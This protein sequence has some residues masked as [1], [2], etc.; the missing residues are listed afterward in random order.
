[1]TAKLSMDTEINQY[2]KVGLSTLNTYILNQGNDN[3]PLAHVLQASPFATPYDEEGN[4]VLTLAGS[5]GNVF[6]PLLDEVN[7]AVIDERKTFS[8]F[9]TGYADIK[10]PYGFTYRFNGGVNLKYHHIGKFEDTYTTKR[11]SGVN[12]SNNENQFTADYTLENI[13]N[14]NYSI[15]KHN[16]FFT[17]LYSYQE[18]TFERTWINSYD[19]YD[20]DVQYYNPSKAEEV[21]TDGEF[22]KWTLLS[23]MARL[24]YNYNDKYLLTATIRHDGS[25]RLAK[26]NKW[27]SFPSIALGWNMKK[28]AFMEDI[29]VLSS[30]KIRASWGNVGSTAI[31][32]YQTISR[33]TD[34]KYILGDNGVKGVKPSSV[35][36]YSL[37]WENTETI[38]LGIDFGLLS[39]RITGTLELY[40][41]KTTNVLL[42]VKLP[43]TSG[44]AD[45]Y[46]TNLGATRNRGWEFNVSAVILPGDGKNQL[47]WSTDFN[48]FGNRFRITDLGPG[49]EQDTGNNRFLG[50]DKY[51]IYSYEADGLWQDTPEDRTLAISYSLC[52]ESTYQSQVLGTIKIKNHHIDYEEDG[53]TPKE[54]QQINED[55]RVF[56]GT[57]A[58][59]FEGGITNRFAY[60]NF[61]LSFLWTYKYGGIITSDMHGGYMNTLRGTYNNLNVDYWTPENTGARWPR[62]TSGTV[63]N[64]GLL[65]RYDGSYLKLRNLTLGYT[66][67]AVFLQK[68]SVASARVYFTANNV[69]TWFSKEYRKD[70]GID[71]ET[72]S[73]IN[74]VMLPTRSFVFGV[75]LSF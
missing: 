59:K 11:G 4:L 51:V 31:N 29:D 66:I 67:P 30:L 63:S 38:N 14:W 27:R 18:N 74:L 13:L 52:D 45:D 2:L 15:H 73:T 40:Q 39:N 53:V 19:Y 69:Y 60:K 21:D 32:P 9:T 1:M 20:R 72:T 55:D 49:V 25:S 50:K 28:E 47:S 42:G 7:G 64:L 3:N 68:A 26:G 17:G 34:N 35:P 56:L 61:D 8:T 23:Y 43:I 16:F 37:G 12:Y 62:P 44:Y 48:I 24:N 5:N 22:R 54:K 41:Q 10:L 58:P 57:R 70:G 36:D 33:L 46:V 75:N 65:A 6:N 71:P